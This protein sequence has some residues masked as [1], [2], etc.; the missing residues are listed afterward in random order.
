MIIVLKRL[1]TNVYLLQ[2]RINL[3]SEKIKSKMLKILKIYKLLYFLW[4][5][6]CVQ[7]TNYHV[8]VN[9]VPVL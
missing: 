6:L 2:Y 1:R 7:Y 5:V 8:N 4:S 9:L 3:L